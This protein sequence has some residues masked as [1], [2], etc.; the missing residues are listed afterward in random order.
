MQ[1]PER[2]INFKVYE[3]GEQFIGVADIDLPEYENMTETVSGA[4][5]MGELD[6]PTVGHYG[7]LSVTLN[8]RSIVKDLIYLSTP[9]THKLDIR[10]AVQSIDSATGEIVKKQ[11][12]VY[13]WCLPKKT[14]AGK[15][16]K[17]SP[18]DSSNELS[19]IYYK[20]SIDGEK[21]LE[22]DILNEI[23]YILGTD[24]YADVKSLL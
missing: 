19:V 16:E 6:T 1:I 24:Y 3:E 15:M 18:T 2:L 17:A 9:K 5:I 13:L 12:R 8:W 4:G 23:C 22:I 14:S 10:G 7:A 20:L 21:M 11:V